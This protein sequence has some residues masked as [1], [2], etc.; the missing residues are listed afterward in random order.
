[1][2]KRKK[3]LTERQICS[4]EWKLCKHLLQGWATHLLMLMQHHLVVV[5]EVLVLPTT[6]RQRLDYH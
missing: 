4:H 1:M 2:K 6:Q 5:V 3:K